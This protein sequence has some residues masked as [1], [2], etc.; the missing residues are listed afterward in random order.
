MVVLCPNCQSRYQLADDKIRPTGTKVRCPRCQNAFK[1]FRAAQEDA[2]E[3][4][5]KTEF[6]ERPP[7]FSQPPR[8]SASR[9]E[10]PRSSD[11]ENTATTQTAPQDF[12]SVAPIAAKKSS[13]SS[14]FKRVPEPAFDP[15]DLDQA[16]STRTERADPSRS[17]SESPFDDRRTRVNIGETKQS[18]AAA[19]RGEEPFGAAAGIREVAASKDASPFGHHTHAAEESSS[20]EDDSFNRIGRES[21]LGE[22]VRLSELSHL[23]KEDKSATQ[24]MQEE[25]PRPFGDA[26]FL[27][28]QR[29][30]GGGSRPWTKALALGAVVATVL[31]VGFF[32][33]T[34]IP[35]KT[36]TEI[37]RMTTTTTTTTPNNPPARPTT[38]APINREPITARVVLRRPSQ[39]YSEQPSVFQDFLNQMAGLP[40]SEQQKPENRSLIAEALI[41][42]GIL[43]GADDQISTG[44]AYSSS[45]LIRYPTSVYGVYGLSS[46]ALWKEDIQSLAD[47]TKR[48]PPENQADPEFKLSQLVVESRLFEN[49]R[50]ALEEAKELLESNPD[51]TRARIAIYEIGLEDP[52]DAQKILGSKWMEELGKTYKNHRDALRRSQPVPPLFQAIDKRISRRGAYRPP[53]APAPQA[54]VAPPPKE[55]AK[56]QEQEAVTPTQP[57]QL[58][59]SETQTD[60]SATTTDSNVSTSEK[61]AAAAGAGGI[62]KK[63][64]GKPKHLPRASTELMAANREIR[65][66]KSQAEKLFEL[67]NTRFKEDK[68]AEALEAYQKA[69]RLNPDFAEVY[70]RLGQ[71]YMAK[72]DKERALRSFKIYLQLKPDS[73]DKQLVEGWINSL[74]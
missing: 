36:K 46:Y 30:G 53:P 63:K 12:I 43:T 44:L 69:L 15:L 65:R 21:D 4:A 5:N 20:D 33:I 67:G 22:N 24:R 56:Q 16:E 8:P 35:E 47:L 25:D 14:P 57:Q 39:W 29:M 26:T 64:D 32:L 31:T 73:E 45:L 28:I 74:Q 1:V 6:L 10:A 66:E 72:K 71:I 19:T 11:V 55:I 34:H 54:P 51:F 38:T 48:W 60:G 27:E 50:G 17:Y 3:L 52:E 9:G 68:I 59:D 61:S 40:I 70:K 37:S 13:A 41:L 18:P 23:A 62:T 2:S 42:N 7:Q 49:A 58:S